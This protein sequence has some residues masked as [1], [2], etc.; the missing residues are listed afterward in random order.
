MRIPALLT[1]LAALAASGV[2]GAAAPT[3]SKV[4]TTAVAAPAAAEATFPPLCP[5]DL[6]KGEYVC[7]STTKTA[8]GADPTFPPICTWN[9]EK[10]KYDCPDDDEHPTMTTFDIA[11]EANPNGMDTGRCQVVCWKHCIAAAPPLPTVCSRKCELFCDNGQVMPTTTG[12]LVAAMDEATFPPSTTEA[13][14]AAEPTF[15]PICTWNLGLGVY[16]CPLP[17]PSSPTK[18]SPRA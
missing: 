10:G 18:L 16:V 12:D 11:N 17:N 13:A 5:F 9:P 2:F 1:S 7:P 4:Y 8:P 14:P 3:L 6:E 15:P